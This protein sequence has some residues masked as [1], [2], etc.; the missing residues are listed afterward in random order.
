MAPT[1]NRS[2]LPG[3]ML[4]AAC[5][6]AAGCSTRTYVSATGSTPPQFTHVFITTQAIWLHPSATA[7][8]EDEG[9]VRFPLNSPVTID[10]ATATNGTLMQIIGGLKI[11]PGTYQQIQLIPL[12][13]ATTADPAAQA[14]GALYNQE[15]DYLES[16][17]TPHQVPLLIP[18]PELGIRLPG[19][20]KVPLG[21]L[22]TTGGLSSSSSST[23]DQNET[24]RYA[25]TFDAA[26][27]VALFTYGENHT[28][29]AL[30]TSHG[31][32]YDLSETGGITGH[33][34]ITTPNNYT[35]VSSRLNLVA[36]AETLSADGLRHVA[37]LSA[38]VSAQD[39]SFILY[40]LPA[41]DD[42]DNPTTYDVVIHGAGIQTMVIK[43]VP[44]TRSAADTSTDTS[45]TTF[46]ATANTS[47]GSLTPVTAG[48]YLV[49]VSPD[50]AVPPGAA[51]GFYQKL[52]GS[53]E[54]PYLIE[55]A[56]T[57][58]V[59]HSLVLPLALSSG[60]VQS[61]SYPT[62]TTGSTA[63]TLTLTSAAPSDGS[64]VYK[65][66]TLASLYAMT[67]L[68]PTVSP[69]SA[70]T[71]V[72]VTAPTLQNVQ[73]GAIADTVTVAVSAPPGTYDAGVLFVTEG[74]TLV[75]STVLDGVLA[76]GTGSV[77][78]SNLPGGTPGNSLSAAR[79]SLSALLW[80]TADPASLT[81]QSFP[82][83]LDLR[84]NGVTNA[85]VTIN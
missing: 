22:G 63:Q 80:R 78:L 43:N 9:W 42:T 77:L 50:S 66:G 12:P 16:D 55:T 40:P 11:T 74:G 71:P 23:S 64:G 36:T 39:G 84:A 6:L 79:Y 75:A 26:T 44:V 35:N 25:V 46:V 54:V 68:S 70:T 47:L 19:T 17:G 10:L 65:V 72:Q 8:P 45:A 69:T 57:D 56:A 41:G 34:N 30:L 13:Y 73:D 29:A 53:N 51:I 52:T 5:A 3:G 27:D 67:D 28:P 76:Q 83:T 62:G 85:Q 58:P 2:L 4:V 49:T 18:H 15:V 38:P 61:G 21:S 81:L 48:S 33:I 20:L 32:A 1:T 7:G 59:N 37:V 14:A 82:G 60:A 31:S 24:V